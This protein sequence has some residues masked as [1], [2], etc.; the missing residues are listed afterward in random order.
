MDGPKIIKLTDAERDNGVMGDKK[1]YDAIEAFHTD[2]LV[3]VENAIDVGIIDRLN[4]RM[5]QDTEKILCG[6]GDSGN[7][8]VYNRLSD[9]LTNESAALGGNLSQVPPLEKEWMF[10]EVYANKHA[11]RILSYILGP[12]PEAHFIRTNT[13]LATNERQLVHA[14][15]RCEHPEHPFGVVFNT[16]LVDV[17]PKNGTT[18]LW[19]GTQNTSIDCHRSLGEAIIAE[20]P[21][22]KRR[23]ERPPCYPSIKKGSIVLRDL[24]LWHARR[25]AESHARN[26]NHDGHSIFCCNNPILS[27]WYKNTLETR[28]PES[29]RPTIHI[30]ENYSQSR[31]A[32]DWV[33]DEGYNYFES[34]FSS[35]FSSA[36]VPEAWNKIK[37][38]EPIRGTV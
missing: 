6:G 10:P 35:N 16:C 23:V 24:R 22:A 32:I 1:L 19:L 30:L 17:G 11:V 12:R 4:A 15:L 21:L 36:L 18:E 25:N 14:D 28:M 34:S 5:L 31:Y 20:A 9:N 8:V 26:S 37:D 2:G 3:V 38:L 33:S 7:S 27:R 29:L 13:L